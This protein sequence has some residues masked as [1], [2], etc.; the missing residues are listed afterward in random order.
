MI[1]KRHIL[2]VHSLSLEIGPCQRNIYA[3]HLKAKLADTMTQVKMLRG[4]MWISKNNIPALF[5]EE[6]DNKFTPFISS[7]AFGNYVIYPLNRRAV[8]VS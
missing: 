7:G 1:V 8:D 2:A 5:R 4:D 6:C 3:S